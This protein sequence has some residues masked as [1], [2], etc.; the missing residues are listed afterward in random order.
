M[1][2]LLISQILI[3]LLLINFYKYL[4][5]LITLNNKKIFSGGYFFVISLVNYYFFSYFFLG[6]NFELV[7]F[8]ILAFIIG[9]LDDKLNINPFL[10]LL[11]ISII[12]FFLINFNSEYNINFLI[13]DGKIF[14]IDAPYDIIFT[15]LCF[16][17]LL[18]SI[19]FSDGINCLA[20]LIF[21]F[22]FVFLCIRFDQNIFLLLV[23][24]IS[25]IF[26]LYMNWKNKCFLGDGGVYLLSF[27]VSQLIILN[28]K[29]NYQFFHIEEIFLLLY[30]PGYDLLRLFVSRIFK[31]KNPFKGDNNHIH[32][33]LM[34]KLGLLK[35]LIVFLI[36]LITPLILLS[37]LNFNYLICIMLSI[38]IYISLINYAKN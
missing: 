34:K 5:V 10:R 1:I 33:L 25:L 19:N 20:G 24:I 32:H 2:Y 31:K 13:I 16:L 26:F 37:L 14:K 18:N 8:P 27:L 21:L 9:A 15:C 23:I 22:Y 7:L 17:L 28:Y 36:C 29:S 11:L 6:S 30:L 3:G 12:V 38:L 4:P 35:T